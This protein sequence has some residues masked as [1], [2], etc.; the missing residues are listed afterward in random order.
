MMVSLDSGIL[1][2]F[3]VFCRTGGCIMMLPGFSNEHIPIRARLYIAI[4]ATAPLAFE[5]GETLSEKLS[6]APVLAIAI[7]GLL[8]LVIGVVLGLLAR[9]FIMSLETM[10]TAI[11]MAIGI[12]NVLGGHVNDGDPLP[13]MADFV[14]FGATAMIFVTDLHWELIRGLHQSYEFIPALSTPNAAA[15]MSDLLAAL[16]ASWLLVFQLASPFLLFSVIINL[17]FGFLNRMTPHVSVY[18]LASPLLMMFGMYWFYTVS[19]DF[20]SAF[21][22]AAGDWLVGG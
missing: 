15:I 8:E 7:A 1:A 12:G 18:F 6:K 14:V 20:F 10:A 3:V 21:S 22:A 2:G 13:S 19:A 16:R 5:M 17:G 11:V 9:L 4:A